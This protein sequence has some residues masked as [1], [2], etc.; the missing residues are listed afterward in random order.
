V[1]DVEIEV[2]DTGIGMPAQYL[3]RLGEA[4]SQADTTT[5]RQYGGTGLGLSICRKLIHLMHGSLTVRSA[6][7]EGTSFLVSLPMQAAALTPS[8]RTQAAHAAFPSRLKRVLVAEDNI[9]NQRII[10]SM[11]KKYADEV[12]LAADGLAAY[13]L[14]QRQEY[15]CVFMDGQMPNMDGLEATRLI[16]AFELAH[17]RPRTPIIALTASAMATDRDVFIAS[18]MDEYVTKPVRS[19][20]ILAALARVTAA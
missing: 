6:E 20:D 2:S 10:V 12:D 3:A 7:G 15:D 5:T 8:T 17:H 1:L 16:R 11:L 4:F 19:R 18:G 13:A 14:F 9:V